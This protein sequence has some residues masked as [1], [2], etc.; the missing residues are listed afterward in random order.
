M[1]FGFFCSGFM[2]RTLKTEE[3]FINAS[4]KDPQKGLR[5]YEEQIRDTLYSF[6]FTYTGTIG[7]VEHFKA[8][9][10]YQVFESNIELEVSP[11]EI[12][13]RASRLQI[14]II[15]DL[16]TATVFGN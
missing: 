11:F 3:L 16:L 1:I 14:R 8:S 4:N 2:Q 7:N 10:L 13:L 12:R 15:K 5:W 9:G 6:R